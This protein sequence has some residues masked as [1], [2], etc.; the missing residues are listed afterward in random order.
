MVQLNSKLTESQREKP[1]EAEKQSKQHHN[2]QATEQT[3]VFTQ[4]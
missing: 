4:V 1:E 2:S 3:D